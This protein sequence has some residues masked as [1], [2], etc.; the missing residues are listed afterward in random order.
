MLDFKFKT[1]NKWFKT[2]FK[3]TT[4]DHYR[5]VYTINFFCNSY[6]SPHIVK[7]KDNHKNSTSF[8]IFNSY[9]LIFFNT[10]VT[11][12]TEMD[13]NIR[14]APCQNINIYI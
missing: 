5:L 2:N 9:K 1:N 10:N 3:C 7:K 6:R 4:K 14:L 11:N 12:L 8:V 13:I